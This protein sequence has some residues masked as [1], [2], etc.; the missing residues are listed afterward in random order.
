MKK[1]TFFGLLLAIL[2][3]IALGALAFWLT[4]TVQPVLSPHGA[5]ALLLTD[6][7]PVFIIYDEALEKAD[8]LPACTV[9][10]GGVHAQSRE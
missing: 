7:S 2:S 10:A 9:V 5:S 3:L 1:G 4:V 6:D 8:R